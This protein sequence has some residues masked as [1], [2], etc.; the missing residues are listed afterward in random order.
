M[1]YYEIWV[2]LKPGEKDLELVNAVNAY[3]G[4]LKDKGTIESWTIR[5]RKFGFGPAELGDFN[6]TLS[7]MNLAQ[8]DE[9]FGEAATRSG[10][11]EKLH[12]EVYRRVVDFKSALYRD[13]PDDVRSLE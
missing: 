7:F 5:R 2:N 1:N 9:A 11:V 8:L 3:L 12:V 4:Y 10:E 6:I 13:F